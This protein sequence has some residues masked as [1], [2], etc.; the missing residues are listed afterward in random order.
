MES[1]DNECLKD[2]GVTSASNESSVV[3]YGAFPNGERILLT[4][5]AGV[6]ALTHAAWEAEQKGLPLQRFTFVQVP[7]HGSR[8]NVGPTVLDRL[9]GPKQPQGTPP[10]FVAFVS[11]PKDDSTHPRQMVINAFTRRGAG[12]GGRPEVGA[13]QGQ[14]I[15]HWGGFPTRAGYDALSGIKFTNRVEDYDD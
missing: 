10:K 8:G 1:W 13:T 6:R 15:V 14:K 4:G 7:H 5:D 3:L 12:I 9:L 11:S 2:G